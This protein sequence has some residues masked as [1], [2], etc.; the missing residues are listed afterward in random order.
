ML[1]QNYL[2]KPSEIVEDFEAGSAAW[3]KNG[4]GSLSDDIVNF[5]QGTKSLKLTSLDTGLQITATKAISLLPNDI[6]VVRFMV[7]VADVTNFDHFTVFLT[8]DINFGKHFSKNIYPANLT[9]GWNYISISMME[10]SN[11]GGES[12]T[13]TMIR[14]RFQV[15]PTNGIVTSLS[16]D[17]FEIKMKAVPK[18]L[19]TFDDAW[20][21]VYDQ[22]YPYMQAKGLKGTIYVIKNFTGTAGYMTLPKLQEV[23]GKGWALGNH[24]ADH[25]Q[26]ATLTLAQQ[27]EQLRQTMEWLNMQG[28]K[29]A[30]RHVAYPGGSNNSDTQMAMRNTGMLTGRTTKYRLQLPNPNENYLLFGKGMG[31][32]IVTLDQAKNYV[33]TAINSEST[34]IFYFHRLVDSLVDSNDWSIADFKALVDYISASKIDVVTIDEW[35]EGLSNPRYK[36]LPAS[37]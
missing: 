12:W 28:F 36:S 8:S 21:S 16:F 35:Y 31:L 33:D 29:R 30:S 14:L 7:Y 18:C 13:N 10:M 4:Q 20:D 34:I 23:Y 1:P 6:K 5:K 15:T 22:V 17:K 3:T 26:L 24:T 32:G 11:T 9:V 37:R 19:L 2:L 27:E 25:L